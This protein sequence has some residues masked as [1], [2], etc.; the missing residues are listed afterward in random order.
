MKVRSIQWRSGLKNV[1]GAAG[2]CNFPTQLHIYCREDVGAEIF[3]FAHKLS[4]NGVLKLQML[5]FVDDK[6]PTAQNVGA[7]LFLPWP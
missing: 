3:N 1:G 4:Q 2:S 6:F 5:H 7:S